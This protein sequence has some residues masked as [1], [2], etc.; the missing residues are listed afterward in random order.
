MLHG[1]TPSSAKA[2]TDWTRDSKYLALRFP[3]H[4]RVVLLPTT[5]PLYQW[6]QR[7]AEWTDFEVPSFG[8][9]GSPSECQTPSGRTHRSRTRSLT[10]VNW[11]FGSSQSAFVKRSASAA[12]NIEFIN[13]EASEACKERS[14]ERGN[15]CCRYRRLR[16]IKSND[17]V[18]RI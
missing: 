5:S 12:K 10:P 18:A 8:G 6:A 7:R 2:K 3:D 15:H 16:S 9:Q 17:I 1:S 4:S 11:H 14:D 13:S